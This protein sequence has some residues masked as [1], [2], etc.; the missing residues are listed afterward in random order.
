MILRIS[1]G[2][3]DLIYASRQSYISKWHRAKHN[4]SLVKHLVGIGRKEV[5]QDCCWNG[6]EYC[7][8]T[9][10]S[11]VTCVTVPDCPGTF[12]A[13]WPNC[14]L[15]D[16]STSCRAKD[17]IRKTDSTVICR[18]EGLGHL[19]AS[20]QLSILGWNATV[21][22]FICFTAKLHPTECNSY[23]IERIKEWN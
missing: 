2:Y 17:K 1:Q 6:W 3:T 14:L 9:P 5:A 12:P 15:T 16:T 20:K 18:L 13:C 4:T 10:T 11:C 21:N 22:L 8:F 7:I 23:L 19:S